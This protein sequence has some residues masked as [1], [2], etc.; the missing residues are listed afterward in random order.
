MTQVRQDFIFVRKEARM[1][2][3]HT[4]RSGSHAD[5]LASRCPD[6]QGRGMATAAVVGRRTSRPLRRSTMRHRSVFPV[7]VLAVFLGLGHTGPALAAKAMDPAKHR[8]DALEN[9]GVSRP[10]MRKNGIR[11]FFAEKISA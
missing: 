1:L 9:D 8:L 10:Y 7:F 3:V 2:V 6:R 5:A 11:S 4:R